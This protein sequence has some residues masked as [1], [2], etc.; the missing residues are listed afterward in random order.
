[1]AVSSEAKRRQRLVHRPFAF[2]SV[3]LLC[4]R[5]IYFLWLKVSRMLC[6]VL[7]IGKTKTVWK[8]WLIV[9]TGWSLD[10]RDRT[11]ETERGRPTKQTRRHQS[12]NAN[13][14]A[15]A[16]VWNQGPGGRPVGKT[17]LIISHSKVRRIMP[18]AHQYQIIPS[19]FSSNVL[20]L[21]HSFIFM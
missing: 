13:A 6:F 4:C 3:W 8:V 12:A 14:N 7:R 16:G 1:M 17:S 15:N 20:K 10:T 11:H 19:A 9:P 18:R 21:I 5:F 2:S